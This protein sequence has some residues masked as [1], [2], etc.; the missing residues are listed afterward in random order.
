MAGGPKAKLSSDNFL[1]V[2]V[3]RTQK[4]SASTILALLELLLGCA[5]AWRLKLGSVFVPVCLHIAQCVCVLH[6]VVACL[7]G[8]KVTW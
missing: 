4:N 5:L 8:L 1:C 7:T 2:Y 6:Y 3:H